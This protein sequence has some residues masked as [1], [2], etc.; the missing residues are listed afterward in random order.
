M[1]ELVGKGRTA[2]VW[3]FGEGKVL[4][5]FYDW[6][7]P[8]VAE[9]ELKTALL[10]NDSDIDLPYCYGRASGKKRFSI[11]YQRIDGPSM[12]DMISASPFSLGVRAR[13]LARDHRRI[14]ER[15]HEALPDQ[16]GMLAKAI[17]QSK[18]KLGDLYGPVLERL[19]GLPGGTAVCHGDFHPGNVIVT[20]D[21]HVTIDWMN[22]TH[23]C[24]VSD[25][26]RTWLLLKSPFLPDS[27]PLFVRIFSRLFKARILRAW[28]SE[29]LAISGMKMSDV[30]AWIP[31]MAAARL[32]ENV[33]GEEKWALDL[34]RRG[35]GEK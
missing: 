17:E 4:K 23:G 24:P 30:R 5:E 11:I 18:E 3:A 29:Y 6:V 15:T 10:L 9:Y 8:V 28:L 14:H 25:V 20:K 12:L 19:S 34:V 35:L 2:E 26:A 21:R 1:A 33:P 32:R 13:E 16:K 31:V 27:M 7:S 22:A